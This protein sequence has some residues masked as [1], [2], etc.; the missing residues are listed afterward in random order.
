MTIT[1]TNEI[2]TNIIDPLRSIITTEFQVPVVFEDSFNGSWMT[3]GEYIRLYLLDSTP[4]SVFAG[5]ETREYEIEMVY[6]FDTRRHRTKKAFDDI[7]SDRFE[8]LRSLLDDNNSYNDGTYRWH[9]TRIETMPIQ[10]VSEL[11]DI[12][13]EDTQA[14]KFNV[15]IIRNNDR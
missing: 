8:H 1:Y 14:F 11:E 6:Y 10:S 15:F 2:K 5:G 4:L 3:H 13:N 7:Y 9:Y 12:E